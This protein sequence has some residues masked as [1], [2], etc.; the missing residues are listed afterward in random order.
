MESRERAAWKHASNLAWSGSFWR[1]F[2]GRPSCFRTCSIAT[3]H[4]PPV[5]ASKAQTL[6]LN[7]CN[8][9]VRSKAYAHH[10]T[11]GSRRSAKRTSARPTI[12]SWFLSMA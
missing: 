4:P 6:T 2:A 12:P 8:P 3:V 7:K 1:N 5:R 9:P 10:R 11:S